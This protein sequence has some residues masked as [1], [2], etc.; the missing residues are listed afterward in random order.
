MEPACDRRL[1]MFIVAKTL[2]V[3]EF[4]E[5]QEYVKIAGSKSRTVGGLSNNSPPNSVKTAAVSRAESG[6]SL[7]RRISTPALTIPRLYF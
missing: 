1:Q 5:V 6:Q 2:T 7:S 4:L 3:Q